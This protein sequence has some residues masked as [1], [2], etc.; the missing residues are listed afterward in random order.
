MK[1][2]ID[3]VA[4]QAQK[5]T[6]YASY[7]NWSYTVLSVT[8]SAI[9]IVVSFN[10]YFTIKNRKVDPITYLLLYGISAVV[11]LIS[12]ACII[13]NTTQYNAWKNNPQGVIN[14]YVYNISKS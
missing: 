14:R 12:V 11:L 9:L 6:E 13:D 7:C 4:L 8:L 10:V 3:V 2:D 1:F 5:L